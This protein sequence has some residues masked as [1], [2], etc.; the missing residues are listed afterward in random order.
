[1]NSILASWATIRHCKR[2]QIARP[3]RMLPYHAVKII[4][5][6]AASLAN[7]FPPSPHR[8]T[9]PRRSNKMNLMMN[10][11]RA[12][13][14]ELLGA[15]CNFSHALITPVFD[16]ERQR[17]KWLSVKLLHNG[18]S[19]K[20]RKNIFHGDC[21]FTAINEMVE[22]LPVTQFWKF[23]SF[24]GCTH[25]EQKKAIITW[26]CLLRIKLYFVNLL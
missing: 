7:L 5:Y 17:F 24:S 26:R 15:R 4:L 8:G 6:G 21:D 23:V 25:L 13:P 3:W 16:S 14:F 1:M 11:S 12:F 19:R 10:K 20:S 2:R 22:F 18:K 9:I